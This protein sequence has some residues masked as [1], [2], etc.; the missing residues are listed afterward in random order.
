MRWLVRSLAMLGGLAAA[1]LNFTGC[2]GTYDL[3]TSERFKERPFH[4]CSRDDPVQVL[5]TVQEGDDRVKAMK[6]LK[7]PKESG[8]N[9]ADQDRMMTILQT[10]ATNDRRSLCRLAAVEAACSLRR[11]RAGAI[12]IAAFNNAAYDGS[13]RRERP[14][15]KPPPLAA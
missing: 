11:I 9:S 14:T 3:V 5:E 13:S 8:G 4:R 15:C 1:A 12:L 2:A 10:A 7:E 6:N